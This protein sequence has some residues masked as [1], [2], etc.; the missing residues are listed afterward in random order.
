MRE[1]KVRLR[2]ALHSGMCEAKKGF[3]GVPQG[4]TALKKSPHWHI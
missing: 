1:L 3:H 2:G 4:S